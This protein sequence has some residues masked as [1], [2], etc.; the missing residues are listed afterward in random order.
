MI[1]A[2][3]PYIVFDDTASLESIGFKL[4]VY[5]GTKETDKS[6]SGASVNYTFLVDAINGE[7]RFDISPFIREGLETI[8]SNY[9]QTPVGNA[10][11]VWVTTEIAK[12][13][14]AGLGSYSTY[15]ATQLA[16]YGYTNPED[17]LNYTTYTTNDL[18][19]TSG[20]LLFAGIIS[21]AAA[22]PSKVDAT[23]GTTWDDGQTTN[24][25]VKEANTPIVVSVWRDEGAGASSVREYDVPGGFL[26]G[27]TA[28][29]TTSTSSADNDET[30]NRMTPVFIDA[31]TRSFTTFVGSIDVCTAEIYT[32]QGNGCGDQVTRVLFQNKYGV[33]EEIHFIG[34]AV[35]SYST[36]YDTVK[37][38]ILNGFPTDTSYPLYEPQRQ[39]LNKR[40][41]KRLTVSSGM[42]PEGYNEQF[43]Q[44]LMSNRVW[45]LKEGEGPLQN[46]SW[47]PVNIVETD[48]QY[49]YSRYDK[50]IEYT[51]TFEYANSYINDIS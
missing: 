3:S 6:L 41:T 28:T 17:G 49:K 23:A 13:T 35:E 14:G 32:I 21:S 12:D 44:L 39:H 1:Y 43:K 7:V 36:E 11:Y 37:K 4:Y 20:G 8:R 2:R 50:K 47:D 40:A 5:T 10:K 42:Y 27:A 22:F 31:G 26:S 29:S 38:T 51:F 16:C 30:S 19:N 15:E 48:F 25:I 33:P 45:I 18:E 9:T 34:R 46:D 24:Y